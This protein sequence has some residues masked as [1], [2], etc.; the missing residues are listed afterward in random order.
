MDRAHLSFSCQE[1][2]DNS[3]HHCTYMTDINGVIDFFFFF[4]HKKYCLG[5]IAG[6]L[7]G[8]SCLPHR[9][10]CIL[11]VLTACKWKDNFE[12]IWLCEMAD[13]F[14]VCL[15]WIQMPLYRFSFFFIIFTLMVG[16]YLLSTEP[17]Q[18]KTTLYKMI[19]SIYWQ[20]VFI[21][22]FSTFF[23]LYKIPQIFFLSQFS[24]I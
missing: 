6:V 20:H 15:N 1:K 5:Y 10:M 3:K 11:F 18:S 24:I 14:L 23:K 8:Q 19:W 12:F 16:Y 13:V 21:L 4:V 17:R 7:T 2:K 22:Q 9:L